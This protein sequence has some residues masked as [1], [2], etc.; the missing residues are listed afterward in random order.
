MIDYAAVYKAVEECKADSQSE[1]KHQALVELL[2]HDDDDLCCIT[3][4]NELTRHIPLTNLSDL[5]RDIG[6][7]CR[8]QKAY[9]DRQRLFEAEE[10]ERNNA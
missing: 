6:S 10:L 2:K 5:E 7:I 3:M 9:A 8:E 4:A 1:A